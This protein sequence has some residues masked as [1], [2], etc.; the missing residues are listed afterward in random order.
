MENKT[1]DRCK[2]I[3]AFH[4][5]EINFVMPLWISSQSSTARERWRWPERSA[6]FAS[7][8]SLTRAAL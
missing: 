2:Y 3:T 1:K 7:R 8:G 6:E 4:Y 5:A